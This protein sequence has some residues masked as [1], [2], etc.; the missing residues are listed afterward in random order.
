MST[1]EKK[2]VNYKAE[3]QNSPYHTA[4]QEW[5]NRMGNA[6]AQARSWRIAF[7]ILA[8]TCAIL[9]LCLILIISKSTDHIYVAQVKS[10]GEVINVL[11]LN[12]P[13]DPTIA[14]YEN[15]IHSYIRNIMTLSI[16]PVV[17]KHNW[18]DAYSV[19]SARAVKTLTTIAR[20]NNPI[21]SIGK[22]TKSVNI[23]DIVK[24]SPNTFQAHWTQTTYDKQGK[25]SAKNTWSG[26]FTVNNKTPK[27]N[28]EMYK[29]P[30]GIHIV[31]F[32]LESIQ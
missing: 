24:L 7:L 20:K 17:V 13:F 6:I 30:L 9:S 22:F 32:T 29:N 18:L 16:D 14:Q 12:T 31:D 1:F 4:K 11:P 25:V 26:V 5:D 10:S 8:L 15:F 21:E 2:E 27:N 23:T 19:S 28:I 3:Q